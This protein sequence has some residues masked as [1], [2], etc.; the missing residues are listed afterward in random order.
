MTF[1]L[2]TILLE[3]WTK[4]TYKNDP[5]LNYAKINSYFLYLNYRW[6]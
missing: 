5:L 4:S 1:Q 6:R 3:K 2:E